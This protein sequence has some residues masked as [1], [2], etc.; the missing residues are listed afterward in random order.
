MRP[1]LWLCCA[2]LAFAQGGTVPKQKP[3]DYDAHAQARDAA[4]G[5]E[6]MVHSFSR[7]EQRLGHWALVRRPLDVVQTGKVSLRHELPQ[8][9]FSVRSLQALGV[10]GRCRA[11]LAAV[12]RLRQEGTF[13]SPG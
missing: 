1:I 2:G 11:G 10:V 6:F 5:A 3:E 12:C 7:G 4:V 8:S 9:S 13:V